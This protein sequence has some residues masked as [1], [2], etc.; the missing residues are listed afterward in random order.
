VLFGRRILPRLVKAADVALE[1]A[2]STLR[3]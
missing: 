3:R 2:L 1:V